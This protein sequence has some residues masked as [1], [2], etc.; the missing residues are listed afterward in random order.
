MGVVAAGRVVADASVEG[1]VAKK[2]GGGGGFTSPR[3]Q[4]R[5]DVMLALRPQLRETKRQGKDVRREYDKYAGQMGGL[6][7]LLDT[8]LA[9]IGGD[10]GSQFTANQDR[11]SGGVADIMAAIGQSTAPDQGAFLNTLGSFA[12][13]GQNTLGTDAARETAYNAST[14][15]QGGLE[16]MVLGRNIR[17]DL[18]DAL[19]QL[20]DERRDIMRDRGPMVMQ[21]MDT[22]RQQQFDRQ[23]ALKE[24]A[25]RRAAVAS[26]NGDDAAMGAFLQD[27]AKNALGNSGGRGGRR[28]NRR[29]RGGG[30]G[31]GTGGTAINPNPDK[32]RQ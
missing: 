1:V 28:R 3:K 11:Y 24:L 13:A 30:G 5:R 15:R 19:D 29:R 16:S 4:A 14:R 9:D 23:M 18:Q 26:A 32:R 22:L 2:K 27:Y 12:L 21:R 17:S 8:Q 10:M 7:G 6:Y 20:R 31:G 25:L